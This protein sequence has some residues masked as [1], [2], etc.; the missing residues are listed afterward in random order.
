MSSVSM[1]QIPNAGPTNRVTT[2]EPDTHPDEIGGPNPFQLSP[3]AD[4]E[5]DTVEATVSR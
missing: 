5:R 2:L 1:H 4:R 3:E